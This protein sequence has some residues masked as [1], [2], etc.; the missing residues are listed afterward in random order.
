MTAAPVLLALVAV[1]AIVLAAIFVDDSLVRTVVMVGAVVLWLLVSIRRILEWWT[2]SYVIT[3]ER[4][5]VRAGILTRRGTEIPLEMINNVAFSQTLF[6]RMTRSGD[7]LIESAGEGGQNRYTNIPNPE[8]VQSLIYQVR[9]DRMVALKSDNRTTASEI[10]T[11][12]RLREQGVITDDEF[13]A[14]KRRLL[15]G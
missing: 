5:V 12:A 4:V 7:L 14:Q 2:T 11:L 1:T 8:G 3:S 15:G 9:E 13:E 10:E 6:E